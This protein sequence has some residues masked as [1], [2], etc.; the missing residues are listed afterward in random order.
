LGG[1]A[2]P[3]SLGAADELVRHGVHQ[4]ADCGLGRALRGGLERQAPTSI[5]N[6]ILAAG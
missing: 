6:L 5:V 4:V 3:Q 1:E 2:D